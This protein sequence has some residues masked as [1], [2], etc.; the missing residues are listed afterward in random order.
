[1]S[2]LDKRVLFVTGKGGVGKTSVAT[3]I[4]LEAASRGKRTL[5]AETAGSDAVPRL[6][7]KTSRGYEVQALQ[8]KLFT[9]SITGDKAIE[10]YIVQQVKVRALYKLVF[11]NRVMGPFVDAVPGLHDLTQ[12]GKIFDLERETSF[13]RPVWDLIV[14]DAPATGHGLTLLDSPKAMMD[15]TVAGPFH[16]NAKL[17]HQLFVDG[18]KVGIVLVTLPEAMPVN[19]TLELVERLGDYRPQVELCVLNEVHPDVLDEQAWQAVREHVPSDVLALGERASARHQ[20]QN[21]A[22]RRLSVLPCPIKEL[23]FLP[24]RELTADELDDMGRGLL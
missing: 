10:D 19:E 16:E 17:V 1:V 14:V 23:P 4:A 8:S 22:R 12:L 3:A 6:F 7:G 18:A 9:M 21:D 11:R 15:L 5:L 20:A 2:L 24:G 13:G